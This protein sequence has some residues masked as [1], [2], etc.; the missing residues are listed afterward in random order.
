MEQVIQSGCKGVHESTV[1]SYHILERV[2]G[3]L[4]KDTPTDVI[5]ELIEV[6]EEWL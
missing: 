6:M 3:Y 1:R 4:R 5:L 2:K